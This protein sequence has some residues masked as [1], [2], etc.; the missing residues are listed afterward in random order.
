MNLH[1]VG[2][3]RTD[4]RIERPHVKERQSVWTVTGIAAGT[5]IQ[6]SFGDLPIEALRRRDPVMTSD[7]EY[8]KVEWIDQMKLDAEFMAYHP[9]AQPVLITPNSLGS[10]VPRRPVLVSPKQIVRAPGHP[11]AATGVVASA[12]TELPRISRMPVEDLT[13]V[14]LHCGRPAEVQVEGLWVQTTP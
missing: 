14:R 1:L 13:Y 12:L 7:H 8:A 11:L 10:G 3:S 6:T 5:R 4:G 2:G 9:E